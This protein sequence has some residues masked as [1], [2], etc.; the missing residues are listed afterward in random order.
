L[1]RLKKQNDGKSYPEVG[2]P[3]ASDGEFV[4]HL[5]AQMRLES[6]KLAMWF[7]P[8]SVIG[9]GWICEKHVHIS[10]VC[11]MLALVGFFSV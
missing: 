11:V 2:L 1:S 3:L 4:S 9:F 6:T 10:A 7:L 8:P 5:E